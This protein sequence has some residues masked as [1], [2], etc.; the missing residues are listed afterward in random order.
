M[1]L[2][3]LPLGALKDGLNK[4]PSHL[5]LPELPMYALALITDEHRENQARDV[6]V[7]YLEAELNKTQGFIPDTRR[8]GPE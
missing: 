5:N 8:S 2:S 1:G 4:A 7:S 6:F 3:V